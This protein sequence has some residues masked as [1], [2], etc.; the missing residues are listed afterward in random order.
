[1][2]KNSDDKL[3]LL[4]SFK[5]MQSTSHIKIGKQYKTCDKQNITKGIRIHLQSHF[6][7]DQA[8]ENGPSPPRPK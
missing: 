2:I 5:G 6:V 8:T 1:M 7:P 4:I 3:T